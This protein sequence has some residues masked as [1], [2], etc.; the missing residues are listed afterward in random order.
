MRC[1]VAR[2]F[3]RA[4]ITDTGA[5]GTNLAKQRATPCHH[6]GCRAAKHCAIDI[7]PDTVRH[8]VGLAFGQA[9]RRTVVTGDRTA[10]ARADTLL[11]GFGLHGF[12]LASGA[13]IDTP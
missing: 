2:A 4:Q 10:I 12:L 7:V 9:C 5:Q 6:G 8:G 1:L 11:K 3:G 13:E